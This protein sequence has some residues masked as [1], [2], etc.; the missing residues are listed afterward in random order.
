M[1]DFARVEDT[2]EMLKKQKELTLEDVLGL[3]LDLCEDIEANG[4]EIDNLKIEKT[5]NLLKNLSRSGRI[6]LNIIRKHSEEIGQIDT[7]GRI[8]K[9]EEKLSESIARI[10]DQEEKLQA[11]I[12]QLSGIIDEEQKKRQSYEIQLQREAE[13]KR[14]FEALQEECHRLSGEVN[15]L[16]T[17]SLEPLR[18]EQ[19]A[20][21]DK[22]EA[23]EQQ[24]SEKQ[25]EFG[26]Q[27]AEMK[28]FEE[29]LQ[30]QLQ[31]LIA[32]RD[33]QKERCDQKRAE[34]SVG[35]EQKEAE[36]AAWEDMIEGMNTE[37]QSRADAI[38]QRQEK[39]Q[40]MEGT[41]AFLK[42]EQNKLNGNVVMLQNEIDRLSEHLKNNDAGKLIEERDRLRQ[43]KLQADTL[44]A[45]EESKMNEQRIELQE[46]ANEL[47]ARRDRFEKEKSSLLDQNIQTE[48]RIRILKEAIDK[49][50][51]DKLQMEKTLKETEEI[52][53]HLEQ[54][55]ESLEV[56]K[57]SD[58][59]K[60]VEERICI[61]KEV[62]AALFGETVSLGLNQRMTHKEANE[63][64]EELREQME[65]L[66]ALTENYRKRY[67]MICRLFSD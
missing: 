5:E 22:K 27:K 30:A 31:V 11:S 26:K 56:Q 21:K 23:L 33:A 2:L 19:Q 4:Q 10:S 61:F 47:Q 18:Q 48:S 52:H 9:Q 3:Y 66:E 32:E 65:T 8:R 60:L 6:F 59:L 57:Y 7:Y 39:K 55:F 51:G 64:R 54:W 62:Q 15:R 45:Q 14:Q 63:K 42:E 58:R 17:I 67:N 29:K 44:F 12:A 20:L 41:V 36:L 25:A 1:N 28:A 53:S 46:K 50:S 40:E 43:E 35:L 34:L 16:S 49:Y 38:H 37:I 24:I 13:K